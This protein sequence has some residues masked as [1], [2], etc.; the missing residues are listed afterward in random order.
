MKGNKFYFTCGEHLRVLE[1]KQDASLTDK[2]SKKF[3]GEIKDIIC[4]DSETKTF[5]YVQ[6][7][8]IRLT[9]AGD[10]KTGD[11]NEVIFAG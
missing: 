7:K 8:E 10:S 11:I 4:V 2:Y 5:Y 3:T 6:W 1:I 9:A